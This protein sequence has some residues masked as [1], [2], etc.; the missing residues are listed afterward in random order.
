MTWYEVR[1]DS[2]VSIRVEADDEMEALEMAANLFP[3]LADGS[4]YPVNDL[5]VGWQGDDAEG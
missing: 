2:G 5:P 4:V 1:D 3:E